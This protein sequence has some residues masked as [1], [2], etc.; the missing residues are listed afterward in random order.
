MILSFV[1]GK[2]TAQS[3]TNRQMLM[4]DIEFVS[5]ADFI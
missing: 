4:S 1:L 2:T 3:D 5:G